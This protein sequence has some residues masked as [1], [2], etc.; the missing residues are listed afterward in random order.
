MSRAYPTFREALANRFEFL[1]EIGS[2]A[3]A[4]VFL[5]RDRKHGRQVAV[6]MLRSEFTASLAGERF[7]REIAI[8]AQLQHPHILPLLD[9]G[10][11]GGRFY[12]VMPFVDGET[13]R[14]RVRREGRLGISETVRILADIADA[15]G[16]AHDRG[17]VHRDIKPDNIILT[18]RHALVMDF[19]VAKAASAAQNDS[20][21]TVG[22]AL[23]TPAYMSPEQAVADPNV[24]HRADLYALGAVG[25]ELLTGR[26]PFVRSTP[27][28]VLTAHV[29]LTPESVDGL[30]PEVPAALADVVMRALAKQPDGRWQ[31]AAEIL[32]R[33]DPL[34]TP[35]AG[36]TPDRS[37][38]VRKP[39]GWAW[40]AAGFA[41]IG[42]VALAWSATLRD[43]PL[44]L[45][46]LPEQLSFTGTVMESAISPDGRSLAVVQRSDRS[47]ALVIRDLSG[48]AMITVAAGTG[49]EG[50]SWSADGTEISFNRLDAESG[51]TLMAVSRLGGASRPLRNGGGFRSPD[52]RMVAVGT[53]S[54]RSLTLIDTERGDSLTIALSAGYQW[55]TGLAWAADSKRLALT[56]TNVA[57]RRSVLELIALDGR[58]TIVIEDSAGLAGP[59]FDATGP[60]LYYLRGDNDFYTDLMRVELTRSGTA[61]AAPVLAVPGLATSANKSSV[62]F[63]PISL[64]ADG[65]RLVYTRKELH[66]N[67]ATLSLAG[68]VSAAPSLITMG[69]ALYSNPR[70]SPDGR[71]LVVT[72]ER[73]NAVAV[74][75]VAATGGEIQ[76]VDALTDI[77]QVAWSTDGETIAY[78]GLPQ[79]GNWA[80][81]SYDRRAGTKRQLGT[82]VGQ[83]V[84]WSD[85]RLFVTSA[86]NHA[87]IRVDPATGASDTIGPA[88][89]TGFIRNPRLSPDGT[90]I[91]FGWNRP[92]IGRGTFVL[93]LATGSVRQV[94]AA[95]VWPIHWA[96]DGRSFY[97]S[98]WL[99]QSGALVRIWVDRAHEQ[100]LAA[101]PDGYSLEDLSSDGHTMLLMQA[102]S[103]S[104]AI[105]LDVRPGAR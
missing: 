80:V 89:T 59:A 6:K 58:E 23:G 51:R 101:V 46:Y 14:A 94:S 86:D 74:A 82:R 45:A 68:P 16:Y 69:T 91:A 21:L 25:F 98:D 42:V 1:R 85:T 35:P 88:D 30:R 56:M 22:L 3:T 10:Q 34:T 32:E 15:L 60:A 96:T 64:T 63:A 76:E 27:Q 93:D 2:G 87:L 33:L 41:L 70:L 47:Q 84:A 83:E 54:G 5:A 31:R 77:G 102:Q 55:L 43:R 81:V 40:A 18:G 44:A 29:A 90:R 97:G 72:V 20:Q 39:G 28:E 37:P 52:G 49:I 104:D 73:Y 78:T 19:G 24:D 99:E 12:F 17:V 61:R 4:T 50:I 92:A 62:A 95:Y 48:Q 71:A 66:S 8:A 79:R 67:L 103:R 36:T 100:T 75:L 11:A 105:A 13:L 26:P 65:R 57:D 53:Q 7:L 38:P 9:S